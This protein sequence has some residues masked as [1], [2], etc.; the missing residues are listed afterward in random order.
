MANSECAPGRI[1]P[2][3]SLGAGEDLRVGNA[4]LAIFLQAHALAARHFRHLIER[5]NEQ[6]AVLPDDRDM[7]ADRRDDQGPPYRRIEIEQN[8]AFARAADHFVARRDE[9]APVARSDQHFLAR[10][11]GKDR[12]DIL[13]LADVGHEPQG[14]ALAAATRQFR[15]LEREDP[16]VAGEHEDLL[17][18]LG[19]EGLLQPSSP[20]N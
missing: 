7:I 19:E 6:L 10:D 18:R 15:R 14:L 12:D 1:L 5:E 13:A 3:Q 16:A 2:G 4:A 20:L 11:I 17:R 9:A 8:L